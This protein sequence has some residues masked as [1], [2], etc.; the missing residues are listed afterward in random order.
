[1]SRSEVFIDSSVFIG[2]L[3]GDENAKELI[4]KALNEGCTLVTNPIVF[5]E[6]VYKVMFTLA[7]KNG[8]KGIHDLRK[9]LKDYTHVYGKV[10]EAFEKL[11]EAGFLRITEV[12][13]ETIRIASQVGRDYKLLPNDALIAASCKENGIERIATF[14]SD[15][16]RVPFLKIFGVD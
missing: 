14:D 6:T 12:T 16:K 10:E 13:Q 3:L 8:L 7:L 5:S 9:H 4:K 11:E 1:M 2:L 15:F